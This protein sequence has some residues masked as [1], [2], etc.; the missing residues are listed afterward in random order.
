MGTDVGLLPA[1]LANGFSEEDVVS[2]SEQ[3]MVW[4]VQCPHRRGS[5]HETT[6]QNELPPSI[7]DAQFAKVKVSSS[8][9]APG[10]RRQP[11]IPGCLSDET[12]GVIHLGKR[13]RMGATR[14][15]SP[16]DRGSGACFRGYQ[17][18]GQSATIGDIGVVV[19]PPD[20]LC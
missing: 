17:P 4:P 2:R 8:A 19:K 13:G 3:S 10:R 16:D 7:A 12:H 15:S 18:P 9:D 20:I 6:T 14:H 5:N 11:L 1:L